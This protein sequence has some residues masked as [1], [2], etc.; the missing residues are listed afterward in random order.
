M[1]P[2]WYDDI[3]TILDAFA[4]GQMDSTLCLHELSLLGYNANDV[5]E[6]IGERKPSQATP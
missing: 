4:N 5:K 6:I 3:E 1:Q 2:E